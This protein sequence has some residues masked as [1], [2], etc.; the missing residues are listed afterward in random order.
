MTNVARVR[1]VGVTV[2]SVIRKI[3]VTLLTGGIAYLLATPLKPAEAIILSAFIGGV[4]LV[5]QFLIEFDDRMQVVEDEQTTRLAALERQQAAHTGEV[6]NLVQQSFLKISQATELFGLVEASALRTDAV[7][8]LVQHSTALTQELPPLV[9][10]V[11]Q[12]EIVR[13]SR[14]LKELGDGT[15]SYEGED[16]DWLLALAH[17]AKISIDAT[18]LNTV[19]ARGRGLDSTFW[20]SDLG[21]RYLEVQ[22]GVARN[23]IKIRRIFIVDRPGIAHGPEFYEMCRLQARMNIEVRILTAADLEAPLKTKL[24]DFILFDN[25]VSYETTP[26]YRIDESSPPEIVQTRMQLQPDVVEERIDRFRD[27][28]ERAKPFV[29]AD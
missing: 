18:S 28:W 10:R 21:Q 22:R 26:A 25:A 15:A 3:V 11:A 12:A 7:I 6:R 14:F 4:V 24:L 29:M 16:R 8:Q 20:L 9:A 27:L 2:S 19:D 5:V 23:G 13:T 17:N 1:G